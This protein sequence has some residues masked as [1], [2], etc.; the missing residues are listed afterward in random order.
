MEKAKTTFQGIYGMMWDKPALRAEM[1]NKDKTALIIIDMVNGF[2]RE[3]QMKNELAEDIIEPIV[4]LMKYFKENRMPIVA[5]GDCHE[6][7]SPE[8]DRYPE[9]CVKGSTETEI[10][11]EIAEE[12][13]Y[14]YIPKSS[15]NAFL[16]EAFRT[17]ME[18]HP[19]I[20]DFVITGV[21]TDICVMQFCLTAKAWFDKMGKTSRMI[22]PLNAV[23][24]YEN[25]GHQITLTN[26]MA[27]YFME[28]NGT[29]VYFEIN[30]KGTNPIEIIDAAEG[31]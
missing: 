27:V 25:G 22:L 29:E 7:D 31:K 4:D 19:D 8:F 21:C 30:L 28:E 13:G 14:D 1:L 12:G 23:E 10:V 20:T 6:K 2:V 11:K 17:W 24:T 15:T 16:E 18:A 3:G 26:T 5:F 9:H